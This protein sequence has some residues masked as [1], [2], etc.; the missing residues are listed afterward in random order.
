MPKKRKNNRAEEVH[1]RFKELKKRIKEDANF[2]TSIE[3][4]GEADVDGEED[5]F[6]N[7]YG[8]SMYHLRIFSSDGFCV[9]NWYEKSS[10]DVETGKLNETGVLV[11]I[12]DRICD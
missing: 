7:T 10:Y 5:F 4:L 2:F 3:V 1:A 11:Y 12:M 8:I 9:S 6:H